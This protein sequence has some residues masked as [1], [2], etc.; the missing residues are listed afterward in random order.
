MAGCHSRRR[1]DR[2]YPELSARAVCTAPL[3][4]LGESSLSLFTF[5]VG[6]AVLSLLLMATGFVWLGLKHQFEV[7]RMDPDEA[8][9]FVVRGW[10]QRPGLVW[11]RGLAT[12]VSISA[13]KPTREI[14]ALLI[15]GHFS[16]GLPWATPALGALAAFFFWP[17]VVGML[18]GLHGPWLWVMAGVFFGGGLSAAWPRAQDR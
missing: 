15:G 14:V 13:E 11:F 8:G 18:L 17:L 4:H 6:G 7:S 2:R 3:G 9:D 5:A 1:D 10:R 16:E 12:G